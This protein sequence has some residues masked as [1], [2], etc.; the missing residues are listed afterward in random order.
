[1]AKD[2]I[3][4]SKPQAGEIQEVYL[5]PEEKIKLDFALDNVKLDV[6]GAD[7]NVMFPDGSQIVFANLGLMLF[8]EERPD[9]ESALGKELTPDMLLSKIGVVTA[10][11]MSN[12]EE[13][14]V[15]SQDVTIGD[16]T[17]F[18]HEEQKVGD[19]EKDAS[20]TPPVINE[21]VLEEYVE[22]IGFQVSRKSS[23]VDP[24]QAKPNEFTTNKKGDFDFEK[25]TEINVKKN[26]NSQRQTQT[27]NAQQQAQK[28]K[29]AL[30]EENENL[31]GKVSSL[32]TE[33]KELFEASAKLERDIEDLQKNQA[34]LSEENESLKGNVSDLEAT[35]QQLENAVSEINEELKESKAENQELEK[36]V[37][38]EKEKSQQQQEEIEQQE[39]TIAEQQEEIESLNGSGIGEHLDYSVQLVQTLQRTDESGDTPVITGGGGSEAAYYSDRQQLSP[40]YILSDSNDSLVTIYADDAT[41]FNETH[42]TR[43]LRMDAFIPEGFTLDEV[44]IDGFPND[45]ELVGLVKDAD[46]KYVIANPEINEFSQIEFEIRYAIPDPATATDL[47]GDAISDEFQEFDIATSL[48]ATFDPDSGY[49]TPFETE[50]LVEK[51]IPAMV[52][53]AYTNDD[54]SFT[55]SDGDVGVVF[56]TRPNNNV[57]VGNNTNHEVYGGRGSDNVVLGSGNDTINTGTGDDIVNAGGGSDSIIAGEG[58]DFYNGG[59]GSDSYD[60]SSE[61]GNVSVDMINVDGNNQVILSVD[62]VQKDTLVSIENIYAGAGDDFVGGENSDNIL[63]GG[64]GDDTL[65]GYDGNDTLDGGTGNN[66]ADYSYITDGTALDINLSAAVDGE[67]DVSVNA[68]DADKLINISGIIGGDG[69]DSFTGSNADNMI[70]GGEGNDQI[71][72]SLGNDTLD[73]GNGTDTLIYSGITDNVSADLFSVNADGF[74]TLTAGAKTDLLKN[75]ENITTGS[76]NDSLVG[77]NADNHFIAGEGSD[78]IRGGA[79]ADRVTLNHTSNLTIDMINDSVSGH[80]ADIDIIEDIEH[81]VTGSG[82]DTITTDTGNNSIEAGAGNDIV[83]GSAGNDTLIGG[84]GIN[85]I[86]YETTT[87][88]VSI[89]LSQAANID[90]INYDNDDLSQGSA[91]GASIGSDILNNFRVAIGTDFNDSI[92]GSHENNTVFG[93][94]GDDY[95]DMRGDNN[96][97]IDGG[98]GYDHLD[99]SDEENRIRIDMTVTETRDG[100]ED[101]VTVDIADDTAI[102]GGNND[103]V[104]NIEYFT[105]G[106][107]NDSVIGTSSAQTIY[108]REGNDTIRGGGGNDY[109]HSGIGND[110]VYV[111]DGNFTVDGVSGNDYLDMGD[112]TSAV[113]I[114]MTVTNGSNYVMVYDNNGNV[115][116]F[117]NF[118]SIAATNFNDTIIGDNEDNVIRIGS[119]DD[120]VHG[121]NGSDYIHVSTGNNTLIGGNGYDIIRFNYVNSGQ[122][123]NIQAGTASGGGYITQFSEFEEYRGSIY[124]DTIAGSN[125]RD[126]ILGGNGQDFI[127]GGAGNDDLDG[128]SGSDFVTFTNSSSGVHVDLSADTVYADGHGFSD[129]IRNFDN[130]T[131]SS[132]DDLLI[133][134]D[135]FNAIYAGA[136]NDTIDGKDGQ[137]KL[138]GQAG[139]DLFIAGGLGDHT[140]IGGEGDDTVD[141]DTSEV[142]INA[143]L[144]VE[145]VTSSQFDEEVKGIE[146]FLGSSH[147]DRFELYGAVNFELLSING[148][149]GADEFVTD[150][151]QFGFATKLNGGAGNDSVT[152]SYG[153]LGND[154]SDI[155]DNLQN[156]ETLDIIA[157]DY[158]NLTFDAQDIIDMTDNDNELDLQIDAADAGNLNIQS[159]ANFN[160]SSSVSGNI[161]TYMFTH[162]TDPSIQAELNVVANS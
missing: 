40:E 124:G 159:G 130:I 97:I 73:G 39:E 119:G 26:D 32:E 146:N 128:Q 99:H 138:F 154:G 123:I 15:V 85:T 68:G 150:A 126:L 117:K 78:T 6:V 41:Q 111:G 133:G 47:D 5:K 139:D 83:I 46:G 87:S 115:G 42:L 135:D 8:S 35:K 19:S 157:A 10:F 81:I 112:I 127:E 95:F 121:G 63:S 4:I 61:T 29:Q 90:Q 54:M 82:N 3:T 60:I 28:V 18:L 156:I 76:G 20:Y 161:T 96:D 48:K 77:N 92:Y 140:Y 144:H 66:V 17:G 155:A 106:R 12:P 84:S 109:I 147:N 2:N 21:E 131:G 122:D 160:M 25:R 34:S 134:H 104:K 125:T 158:G 98:E 141:Y 55:N 57:I 113:N 101:L 30:Q 45:F 100:I 53:N 107:N 152:L 27:A 142:A 72:S 148:K 1:M 149:G 108:S 56:N 43:L 103:Y 37:E 105:L 93:G 94:A 74:S 49:E 71:F 36:E 70:A 44:V 65:K 9:F 23:N 14:I 59:N 110:D 11:D 50:M 51:I 58:N 88:G 143:R 64:D 24:V 137:N 145:E 129:D 151:S 80:N 16:E 38:T 153:T 22:N 120:Y 132:H 118:D 136:G 67:L 86:S 102:G 69:N 13:K 79:G 33:N 89:R 114:D 62:E 7:I 31:G 91:T 162:N 52:K 75:I 116:Q